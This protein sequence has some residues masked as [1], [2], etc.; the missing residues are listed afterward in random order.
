MKKYRIKTLSYLYH[1]EHWVQ[2]SIRLFGIHLFW[3]NTTIAYYKD[4]E[5]AKKALQE[6][7]TDPTIYIL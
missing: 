6:V 7:F 5:D 3:S 1:T 2:R 4:I